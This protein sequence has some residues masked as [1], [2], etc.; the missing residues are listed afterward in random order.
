MNVRQYLI[1]AA[2]VMMG[3]SACSGEARE[4]PSDDPAIEVRAGF[5]EQRGVAQDY[6]FT[7]TVEGDRRINLSTKVMGR[8]TD[9]SADNGDPV[10]KGQVLIR[11][12][13]DNILAQKR[14]ISAKHS[15]ARAALQNTR[16]NYRRIKSLYEDSSATQKEFDDISTQLKVAESNVEGLNSRLA[17]IE[18]LLDYTVIESPID[19]FVV[20]RNIEVGDLASPGQP[21]MA[22][23]EIDNLKVIASVPES[24]VGLVA[25]GDTAEIGI[26][27]AKTHITGRVAAVNPS[28]NRQSRQFEV[29]FNF[30][31][32]AANEHGVRPGMYADIQFRK[33]TFERLTVPL[34]ALHYRGQ[35]KGIYTVNDEN[36]LILRW[37]RTGKTL[38][39]QIEILSGLTAGEQ[40][41]LTDGRKL[42]EGQKVSIISEMESM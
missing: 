40:Y 41:I 17:E 16:I 34:D 35:L 26:R 30:P 9:L 36:E 14:Q 1:V 20:G 12:K 32:S 42:Q 27:A 33:G 5:A 4:E 19:G 6:Q 39:S 21:L 2:S 8:V 15:E 24:Q 29:E 28:G 10:R 23:E 22:V 18:D 37:V 38:G 11:I 25:V 31:A 13:N 7:G 3:L